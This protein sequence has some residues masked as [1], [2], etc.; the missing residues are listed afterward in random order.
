MALKI[1][2]RLSLP[3]ARGILDALSFNITHDDS[4]C[5][6][7]S[8]CNPCSPA[9]MSLYILE[10]G[11]KL[12]GCK[13]NT[14]FIIGV[15][16]FCYLQDADVRKGTK[17]EVSM[18]ELKEYLSLSSGGKGFD[19]VAA[20]RDIDDMWGITRYRGVHR[21]FSDVSCSDGVLSFESQYFAYLISY[22]DAY[23][24]AE[25]GSLY[26]SAVSSSIVSGRK[27]AAKEV[28]LV[29]AGLAARRVEG[30]A[31]ISLKTLL[32]SCSSFAYGFTQLDNSDANRYLKRTLS[33]AVELFESY[34][35]YPDK[36]VTIKLPEV[37]NRFNLQEQVLVSIRKAV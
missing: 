27:T 15:F 7:I 6:L 33:D 28:V 31:G 19:V 11:E 5:S 18:S 23:Q 21:L 24:K 26:C 2:K 12:I 22:L 30:C 32:M 8:S 35:Y 16:S 20:M 37:I 14:P 36:K 9:P 25:K 13:L 4:D 29:L 1:K 34:C 10:S 3:V 17:F